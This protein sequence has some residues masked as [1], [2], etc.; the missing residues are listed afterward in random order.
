MMKTNPASKPLS[1]SRLNYMQRIGNSRCVRCDYQTSASDSFEKQDKD[2]MDHLAAVH[3]SW[4]LEGVQQS[5]TKPLASPPV[6]ARMNTCTCN[7]NICK[8][9][10]G[11]CPCQDEPLA[12]PIPEGT[13]WIAC[14]PE[15]LPPIGQTVIVRGGIAYRVEG[16][17]I[18]QTGGASGRPIM[19]P[20]THWMK[21]PEL[22]AAPAREAEPGTEGDKK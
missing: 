10:I 2:L 17:W 22:P 8:C 18:S 14:T 7:P 12:T 3:P 16:E 1:E 20:V 9:D 21:L 6:A 19:W 15:T 11:C 13:G 4:M 5:A